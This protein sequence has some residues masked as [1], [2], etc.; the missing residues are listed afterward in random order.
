MRYDNLKLEN[1]ML[2]SQINVHFLFNYLTTLHR[3]YVERYPEA[4]ESILLLADV[5]EYGLIQSGKTGKVN[6][7]HDLIALGKVIILTQQLSRNR[8]Q[9][10]YSCD[11]DDNQSFEI[12]PLILLPLIENV[13]KHGDLSNPDDPGII[14][15]AVEEG[16]LKYHSLNKI[17]KEDD[18]PS[19]NVGVENINRRLQNHYPNRHNLLIEERNHYYEVN[20]TIQL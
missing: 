9:L 12:V 6:L 20:L 19:H 5:M 4:S 2:R 10:N 13:F 7:K 18:L 17:L 8:L 11:I 1:D 16:H 14:K 15:I 3:N